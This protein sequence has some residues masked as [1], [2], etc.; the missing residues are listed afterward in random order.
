M[1]L[2]LARPQPAKGSRARRTIGVLV[3]WL[4]HGYQDLVFAGL[5]YAAVALDVNLLC[6]AGGIF[7]SDVRYGT[8]R[9]LIYDY[10]GPHLVD[11][12]VLISGTLANVVGPTAFS[13]YCERYQPLPMASIGVPLQ[14]MPNVTVDGAGG[15]RAAVRHLV[16]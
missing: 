9:N 6:F 1:A 15:M 2:D 16:E 8:T 14:G 3:D 12:L 7:A 13:R 4:K 11:G 5:H 10:V